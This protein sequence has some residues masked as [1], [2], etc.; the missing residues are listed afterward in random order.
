MEDGLTMSDIL[1]TDDNCLSAKYDSPSSS[2]N[3]ICVLIS[4]LTFPSETN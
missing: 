1:K 4:Y 3:L 2:F